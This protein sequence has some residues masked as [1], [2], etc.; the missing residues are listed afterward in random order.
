MSKA[1]HPGTESLTVAIL[2]GGPEEIPQKFRVL[3]NP[4]GEDTKVKVP[5]QG[6]YEHF[7]R[8]EEFVRADSKTRSV[9]LIVY[10]WT[11]RTEIAE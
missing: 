5:H 11:S 1:S 7:E 9:T 8:D 4:Q 6:G 3:P 10:R 2:E